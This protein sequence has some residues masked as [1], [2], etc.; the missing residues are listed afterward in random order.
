MTGRK[1][2]YHCPVCGARPGKPC[3]SSRVASANSL[4]GGWGGYPE[5]ARPHRERGADNRYGRTR[6]PSKQ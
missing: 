1:I 5:L 6:K 4:G 2:D 3:K